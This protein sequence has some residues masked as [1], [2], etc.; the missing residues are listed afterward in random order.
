MNEVSTIERPPKLGVNLE[1]QLRVVGWDLRR[2]VYQNGKRHRLHIGHLGREK[3]ND[4]RQRCATPAQVTDA[5][6]QLFAERLERKVG[7]VV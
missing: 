1:W 2:V 7:N 6:R 4:V 3:W 5:L